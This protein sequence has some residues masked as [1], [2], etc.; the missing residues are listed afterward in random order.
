MILDI[1][2]WVIA[3]L[4]ADAVFSGLVPSSSVLSAWPNTFTA[5]PLVSLM[6]TQSPGIY[7]DNQQQAA[8]SNLD[9]HVFTAYTVSG[10][11]I[12]A[13]LDTVLQRLGFGLVTMGEIPESQNKTR[14]RLLRYIRGA[15]SPSVMS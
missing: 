5:V 7:L 3:A 1:K 14:H 13:A 2:T 10:L 12:C 11:P 15:I 6:E 4:N 9:I 8:V